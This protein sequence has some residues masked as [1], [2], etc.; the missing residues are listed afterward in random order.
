MSATATAPSGP[1]GT[2]PPAFA[3]PEE[4]G[5]GRAGAE[6]PD[7]ERGRCGRIRILLFDPVTMTR[8]CFAASFGLTG[9]DLEIAAAADLPA[10]RPEAAFDVG[11][12]VAGFRPAGS[13]AVLAEV[14]RLRDF[15]AP[16]PIVV[17]AGSDDPHDVALSLEA[18]ARGYVSA[19][20][21][22]SVA[23]AAIRL[24]AVGG[25][26]IPASSLLRMF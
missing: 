5:G 12:V 15:L 9:A 19:D 26:F 17:L 13:E 16:A 25:R 23:V 10:G 4:D 11:V 1:A 6:E 7:P 24:V 3:S 22:L 20:L 14:A 8:Q 21:D 18:G 2:D